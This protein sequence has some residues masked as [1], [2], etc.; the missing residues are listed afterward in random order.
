MRSGKLSCQ[1]FVNGCCIEVIAEQSAHDS[2][3]VCWTVR[4]SIDSQGKI[5]WL[6]RLEEL[7]SGC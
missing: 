3:F 4:L 6:N 5:E 1:H 2:E 7:Q